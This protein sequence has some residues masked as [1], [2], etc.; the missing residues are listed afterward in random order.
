ML[1]ASVSKKTAAEAVSGRLATRESK[2]TFSC[3]V[4]ACSSLSC[5]R[6]A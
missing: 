1:L 5:R 6:L 4:M 2:V 3:L